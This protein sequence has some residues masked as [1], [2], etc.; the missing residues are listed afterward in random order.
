MKKSS[1]LGKVNLARAL[2]KAGYCSRSQAIKHI[3]AGKVSVNGK[4]IK[5]PSYRC[6]PETDQFAID[7]ETAVR[8]ESI[9]VALNK[10]KGYVTTRSDEKDRKTVYDLLKAVEEWVFPVGRLDMDSTGL[11]IF[12]N[13]S[14]FGNELTSP[15]SH[16]PKTYSVRLD[17]TL[18]ENDRKS[19]EMGGKIHGESYAPASIMKADAAGELRVTITEGKN[20]QIR[21][22]FEYF[23]YH[24]VG[25]HRMQIGKFKIGKL[26]EGE[27]KY[28]EKNE[29]RLLMES[30]ED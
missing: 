19:L 11:L 3:L 30:D 29:L 6:V 27:W 5:D 12:T 24:V 17:K 2:S 16:L 14:K 25:L 4:I 23:G 7:G 18:D 10:P 26:K 15:D 20:R 8:P 9:Y 1:R 13:N 28:L 21:K 22:M